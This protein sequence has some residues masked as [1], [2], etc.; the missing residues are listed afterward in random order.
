MYQALG[1]MILFGPILVSGK[2]TCSG[3][4]WLLFGEMCYKIGDT[5]NHSAATKACSDLDGYIIMPKTPEEME[6]AKSLQNIR[7]T[8]EEVWIGL[9][10]T[11]SDGIWKWADGSLASDQNIVQDNT[12][13]EDCVRLQFASLVYDTLCSNTFVTI[14]QRDA[15]LGKHYIR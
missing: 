11:N 10:E 14:C 12:P 1:V 4:D 3:Q 7:G 5:L 15:D 13:G 8:I 2:V 6:F 9:K